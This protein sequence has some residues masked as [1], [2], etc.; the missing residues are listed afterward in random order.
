MGKHGK[1]PRQ[2]VSRSVGFMSAVNCSEGSKWSDP[3]AA[4]S[5]LPSSRKGGTSRRQAGGESDRVRGDA[6]GV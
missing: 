1:H 5:P 2:E 3:V 6:L 4:P